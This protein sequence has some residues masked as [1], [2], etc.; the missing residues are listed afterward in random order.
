MGRCPACETWGSLVEEVETRS[1]EGSKSTNGSSKASASP[2][3]EVQADQARRK[4]TSMPELDRVLGGGFVP[5]SVVLVGGDPG[6]GK[7]TLT[8]QVAAAVGTESATALY[9]TGEESLHQIK[10][11]ADRL[12]LDSEHVQPKFPLLKRKFLARSATRL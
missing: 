11:R 2:L 3:Q 12:G 4:S 7:S 8:L 5:G 6:M 9:V 1:G 10:Q